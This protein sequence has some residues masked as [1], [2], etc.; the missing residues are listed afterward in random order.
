MIGLPP[1]ARVWLAAGVTDLRNGFDG[2]AKIVKASLAEDPQFKVRMGFYPVDQLGCEQLPL[3]V[4]VNGERPPCPT[5]APEVGQHT[6][7]VL[8]RVLGK[9]AAE[10]EKLHKSGILG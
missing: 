1:G 5:M 8:S 10:L 3:P 2:L 7:E 6:D 9:S 4:F